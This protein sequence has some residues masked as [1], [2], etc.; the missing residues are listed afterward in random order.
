MR[1]I[2]FGIF[3]ALFTS[4][5][6]AVQ[7]TVP[8]PR[9]TAYRDS[10]E[11]RG[12]GVG[13]TLLREGEIKQRFIT[14]LEGEF[15]VVEVALFPESGVEFVVLPEKFGLRIDGG[16][17]ARPENPRVIAGFIQKKDASKWNIE[18][19]P[20][21]GVGYE[22]GRVG[23]D[24]T[25]GNTRRLEEIHTTAGVMVGID[26]SSEPNPKNEETMALEL[27][28]KGLPGGSFSRPVAGHLYFRVDSK[29]AKDS[30]I[31]FALVGKLKGEE[32]IL[33]L[34]R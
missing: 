27:T 14:D 32:V 28:E 12:I 29:V 3:G 11:I 9:M 16:R 26:P 15:I 31:R 10:T 34:K 22:T 33:E 2:A 24:P 18:V 19:A 17:T 13:A 7:G 8:L 30:K 21:V 20:H 5:L 23:Y 6:L 1:C 4:I 25:T